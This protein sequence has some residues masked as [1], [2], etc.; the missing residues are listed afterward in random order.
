MNMKKLSLSLLALTVMAGSA[1]ADTVLL[2]GSNVSANSSS[3]VAIRTSNTPNKVIVT[4]PV[5]ITTN[6]CYRYETHIE[7]VPIQCPQPV[8]NT[9][10]GQ[11]HPPQGQVNPTQYNPPIGTPVGGGPGYRQGGVNGCYENRSV[12]SCAESGPV[13]NTETFEIAVKFQNAAS[14]APGQ[15]ETF[16]INA[17]QDGGQGINYSGS[18]MAT[19]KSYGTST[20]RVLMF[21]RQLIFTGQ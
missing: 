2:Q 21:R 7:Q 13:T 4:V 3:F 1:H 8:Y 10:V 11:A 17:A 19:V 12:T 20:A 16:Q 15:E 5:A 18:P 9:P 14:L 6:Q